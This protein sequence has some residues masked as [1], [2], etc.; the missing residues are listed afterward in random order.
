MNKDF[1]DEY[2][3]YIRQLWAAADSFR[4]KGQSALSVVFK[5]VAD[6]K[7]PMGA[8]ALNGIAQVMNE[9]CTP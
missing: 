5:G 8:V 6:G 9:W 4:A 3:Q 1:P 2:L 7:T